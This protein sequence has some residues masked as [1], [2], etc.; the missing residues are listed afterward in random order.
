MKK[1]TILSILL[2]FVLSLNAADKID[3]KSIEGSFDA[4]TGVKE[5]TFVEDWS[6]TYIEDL[7]L[8]DWA[9]DRADKN[10]RFDVSKMDTELKPEIRVMRTTANDKLKGSG[11]RLLPSASDIPTKDYLLVVAPLSIEE[12]GDQIDECV[13]KNSAGQQI[14][15]FYIEASGGTFGSMSNLWGDGFKDAGKKLAK[16]LKKNLK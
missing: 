3:V 15:K 16:I 11:I 8:M 6:R 12:D 2:F 4:L 7:P 5:F 9:R 10:D 13:I 14:V 1:I